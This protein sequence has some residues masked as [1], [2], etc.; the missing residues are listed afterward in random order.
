MSAPQISTTSASATTVTRKLVVCISSFRMGPFTLS[1]QPEQIHHRLFGK[2]VHQ[3]TQDIKARP[4][5]AFYNLDKSCIFRVTF[6]L[7][8]W[9]VPMVVSQNFS[10][11][12]SLAMFAPIRTVI[13]MP[14]FPLITSEISLSPS[15]PS[16]TPCMM[17]S[18]SG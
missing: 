12:T 9:S 1:L 16:S 2:F 4:D 7:N 8:L 14:S 10:S 13:V 15:G 6:L 18:Q 3:R 5:L 17:Q 11:A